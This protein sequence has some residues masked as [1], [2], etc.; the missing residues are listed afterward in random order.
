MCE[1]RA[2][3]LSN[4]LRLTEISLFKIRNSCRNS[5]NLRL[6]KISLFKIRN[7]CRNNLWSSPYLILRNIESKIL[8]SN[9]RG[10]NEIRDLSISIDFCT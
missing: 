8:H 10:A 6:N 5:N 9:S 4:N 7:S 1:N 3:H 2:D